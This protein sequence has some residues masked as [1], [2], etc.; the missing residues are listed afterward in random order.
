MHRRRIAPQQHARR[1][2]RRAGSAR[3]IRQSTGAAITQ[4]HVRCPCLGLGAHPMRRHPGSARRD[5]HRHHRQPDR[6]SPPPPR[7]RH[8]LDPAI[9]RLT[10]GKRHRHG[11]QPRPPRHRPGPQVIGKGNQ[12]PMHQIERVRPVPQ[13][14][15]HPCPAPRLRRPR[16]HQHRRRQTHRQR[17]PARMPRL[18]DAPRQHQQHRPARPAPRARHSAPRHQRHHRAD[19]RLPRARRQ[20]V[21]RRRGAP[22]LQPQA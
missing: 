1:R 15:R 12:R 2:P 19:Q 5:N 13:R 10:Q 6:E 3:R 16:P 11:G 22:R 4:P 21:E 17:R 20:H 18:I 14:H 7:R 9:L 8:P